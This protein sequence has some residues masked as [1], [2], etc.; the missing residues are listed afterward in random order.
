MKSLILLTASVLLAA[1][2]V[3]AQ[4]NELTYKIVDTGQKTF[5]SNTSEINEPGLGESF[6]GQDAQFEGNQPSYTDNGDGTITDNNTGLMWQKDL[7]NQ[8][9]TYEEALEN[10]ETFDLKFEAFCS[11]SFLSLRETIC[12]SFER[13]IGSILLLVSIQHSH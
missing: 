4:T 11:Y 9:F 8:K 12:C 2:S 13:R 10:A 7:L 3:M 5:Y 6:Y 1:A